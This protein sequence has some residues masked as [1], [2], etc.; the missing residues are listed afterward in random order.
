MLPLPPPKKM[1]M[2]PLKKEPFCKLNFIWYFY[3]E[4]GMQSTYNVLH[5]T[6]IVYILCTQYLIDI[7]INFKKS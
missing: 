3:H 4:Y 6:C 1:F 5:N 2:I 7:F